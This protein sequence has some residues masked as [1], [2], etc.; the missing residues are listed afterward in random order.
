MATM[1]TVMRISSA[2][3]PLKRSRAEAR[4]VDSMDQKT[5]ATES[6]ACFAVNCPFITLMT[7]WFIGA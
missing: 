4:D 1:R 2:W 6:A 7:A 3:N 5:A